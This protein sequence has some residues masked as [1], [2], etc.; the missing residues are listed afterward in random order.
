MRTRKVLSLHCIGCSFSNR[1]SSRWRA[2]VFL[3]TQIRHGCTELLRWLK[4]CRNFCYGSS[5]ECCRRRTQLGCD[6]C[7]C[8][9]WRRFPASPGKSPRCTHD[10]V[11]LSR[12]VHPCP[13]YSRLNWRTWL[14]FEVPVTLPP[15][16]MIWDSMATEQWCVV[17]ED[18]LISFLICQTFPGVKA[19]TVTSSWWLPKV[20]PL[21]TA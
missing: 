3:P 14:E 11:V 1:S 8:L 10:V 15:M 6:P 9:R 5:L 12:R 20:P 16:V 17:G 18:S 4:K 2:A 19:S 13:G 7:C 21:P